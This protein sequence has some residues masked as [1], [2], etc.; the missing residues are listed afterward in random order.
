METNT[1]INRRGHT[2]SD[3][4]LIRSLIEDNPGWNRTQ[5]SKRICEL[6]NWCGPNGQLKDIACR[7][8]LRKLERKGHITLPPRLTKSRTSGA[9][10]SQTA[11]PH[12]TTPIQCDLRTL[13][14]LQITIPTC[15]SNLHVLCR[16][17]LQRYHYLGFNT[18][19]GENMMY[20]I[21]DAGQRPLACMLFG[22]AAWH[23]EPRD[24]FIGWSQ[25]TREK[26]LSR[27][28]NNT[29]FLI[30]PWVRVSHLASHILSRVSRRLSTDWQEKYGH[31]IYVLETFVDPSRHRGTCY[32]AAG[33][34]HV[35]RTTGRTRNGGNYPRTTK[36]DVYLH[37]LIKEFCRRLSDDA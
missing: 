20:L 17:L 14:P 26:R 7:D 25:T 24:A 19:V 21:R 3:R 12:C 22:A 28:T 4:H 18:T 13:R 16:H 29:R 1:G 9:K 5:I 27:I 37:P 32:R 2:H 10:R 23:T 15:G 30:L 11:V 6:W 34:I 35:G 31:P 36:K 33:W 8:L